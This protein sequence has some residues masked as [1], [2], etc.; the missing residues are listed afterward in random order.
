MGERKE[1]NEY[2]PAFL[3]P[4]KLSKYTTQK[5]VQIMLPMSIRCKTC[6]NYISNGTKLN[7]Q[8]EKEVVGDSTHLGIGKF[9]LYFKCSNCYAELIMKTDPQN[10]DNDVESGATTDSKLW[11]Q[12]VYCQDVLYD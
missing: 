3:D 9:R 5:K 8:M 11:R 6:Q 12:E 4:F 1:V 7:S 2:Y 10:S